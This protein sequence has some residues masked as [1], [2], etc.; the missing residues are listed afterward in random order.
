MSRLAALLDEL[1]T[2]AKLTHAEVI[3]ILNQVHEEQDRE[4]DEDAE[5]WRA[6]MACQRLT[7]MGSA[8]LDAPMTGNHAH[9]TVNLWS[10][11][12]S[13]FETARHKQDAEG[14]KDFAKFMAIAVENNRK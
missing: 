2:E 14:R 10:A 8:G 6:L 3:A 4:R 13:L 5:K 11:S 9:I 12:R 7:V 1:A